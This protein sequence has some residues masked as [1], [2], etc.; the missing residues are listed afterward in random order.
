[1]INLFFYQNGHLPS[2]VREG[3]DVFLQPGIFFKNRI[4]QH[5]TLDEVGVPLEGSVDV[6]EAGSIIA[7]A[8][9]NANQSVQARPVITATR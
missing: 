9:K 6:K 1:M 8:E 2:V 7:D 3:F 5:Q 4:S